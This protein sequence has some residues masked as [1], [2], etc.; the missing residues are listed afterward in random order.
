MVM[1]ARNMFTR[2]RN[3]Q[4]P[5]PGML[6]RGDPADVPGAMDLLVAGHPELFAGPDALPAPPV[7]F[8]MCLLDADV[9]PA[10][11]IHPSLEQAQAG[12]IREQAR[13][14]PMAAGNR[15]YKDCSAKLEVA[16]AVTPLRVLSGER[17]PADSRLIARELDLPWLQSFT[18]FRHESPSHA[19]LR[20]TAD[21]KA[22]ALAETYAAVDR[23]AAGSGGTSGPVADTVAVVRRLRDLFPGDR[24][25]LLAV[26]MN[27]IQLEPGQA[28]VTPAGCMHT[29]LSGQAMV[30]MGISQN[31]LKLGLTK[32][33]VDVGELQQIL[34]L[35]QP[36]PAPLPVLRTDS[37]RE[38]IPLW[39]EQLLLQRAVLDDTARDIRLGRFTVLLAAL[40]DAEITV[41]DTPTP[42]PQGT[43]VLY[44][45]EP[46]TAQV[47][48]PAQLF[49]ASRN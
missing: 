43:K 25:I 33:Y 31:A 24:G 44:L 20:M 38:R 9:P 6:I 23:A 27:L 3:L 2:P 14:V 17:S 10:I 40:G 34:R 42:I 37:F 47:R 26:C 32:D 30:V 49:T 28:M 48:G 22:R 11:L 36:G 39:D 12:F 7:P 1:L 46:V 45:G 15:N 16:V 19:I 21:E 5:V 8:R 18:A 29:Y 13:G 35:E 41:G 4:T